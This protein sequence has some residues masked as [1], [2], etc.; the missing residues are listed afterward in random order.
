M[1][2]NPYFFLKQS[3]YVRMKYE[4][5]RITRWYSKLV[6]KWYEFRKETVIIQLQNYARAFIQHCIFFIL[7]TFVCSF[8]QLFSKML[9]IER[10]L[11]TIT[12]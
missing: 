2:F 12:S 3:S 10:F 4:N 6:L 1:L 11:K 5:S 8:G 7:Q 9:V